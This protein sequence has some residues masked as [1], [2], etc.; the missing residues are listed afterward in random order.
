[1]V[2]GLN[3]YPWSAFPVGLVSDPCATLLMVFVSSLNSS[4]AIA[5]LHYL[6]RINTVPFS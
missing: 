1:M 2:S 5:G 3:S 4:V 6:L